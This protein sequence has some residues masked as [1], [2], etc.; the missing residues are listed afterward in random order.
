MTVDVSVRNAADRAAV[1]DFLGL[2]T[3]AVD[4]LDRRG[5]SFTASRPWALAR[6]GRVALRTGWWCFECQGDGDLSAVELRISSPQD[7]LV[8]LCARDS[9]GVKIRLDGD[10]D[11]DLSVLISAW[12]GQINFTSLKLR[13]LSSKEE[14]TFLL[15]AAKRLL[16][17]ERPLSL[18]RSALTRLASRQSLGIRSAPIHVTPETIVE[19]LGAVSQIANLKLT[20]L[21]DFEVLAREGDLIHPDALSIVAGEFSRRPDVIALFSDVDSFGQVAVHPCWDVELTKWYPYPDA[22]FFFRAESHDLSADPA[23][24]VAELMSR[25]GSKAIHRIALPLVKRSLDTT[26]G[27]VSPTQPR[28]E[29]TPRV[30]AIIPTKYQAQL[31][32]RCLLGLRESTAYPDLEVVVVDNGATDARYPRILRQNEKHLALRTVVDRGDFNFSRL[33]NRGAEQATG[34]V[35]LLLNDDVIAR[36]PGWLHRMVESAMRKD[37]GAVGARLIYADESVQHA[38]VALGIG[39][40]AGH[41]WKGM[42]K[43]VAATNP[44]VSLPGSRLAVTGAC[45]AVRRE[46]FDAVAGFDQQFAVAFNDID[47]CLR[48]QAAGYR[49]IYRGDAVLTHFESQSR[50]PDDASVS[51]RRRLAVETRLFLERWRPKVED[52][53]YFSPA[54]DRLSE[55]GRPHQATRSRKAYQAL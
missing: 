37:V 43:E 26:P 52:D 9:E 42:S 31:F 38:G 25:F 18:L 23:D 29:R 14:R 33:V 8:V 39:G 41:L 21:G 20:R 16:S 15:D 12:P 22:P 40:A 2:P 27:F 24:R 5:A 48:L 55:H 47:F 46:V 45:L 35:L 50:G 28:L 17:R 11:Y 6:F 30:S 51:T 13:K 1:V 34:E 4:G 44:Y 54:F 53:P 7:P 32:E 36:E 19:T 10:A 3:L 49:N